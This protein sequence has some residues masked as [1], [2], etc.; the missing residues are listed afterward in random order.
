MVIPQR[1]NTRFMVGFAL[2][3][4]RKQTKGNEQI[5]H[6]CVFWHRSKQDCLANLPKAF[7]R[8]RKPK[9]F[10]KHDLICLGTGTRKS[11]QRGLKV[12]QCD[13]F[14]NLV[15]FD[16]TRSRRTSTVEMNSEVREI[17]LPLCRN[18]RPDDYV[19]VNPVTGRPYTDIKHAF[20]GACF[21]AKIERLVW[22]DLRATYGTRSL[23]S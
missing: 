10:A 9:A 18:K 5:E 15:V 4:G 16:K 3:P 20:T 11:E 12:R 22:H 17:L 23:A 14:R 8:A 13:F 2:S 7:G 19:W 21:D 1:E 6:I